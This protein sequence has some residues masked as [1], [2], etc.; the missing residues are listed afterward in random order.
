[1]S[2]RITLSLLM[3]DSYKNEEERGGKSI[4]ELGFKRLGDGEDADGSGF[5]AQ[6]YINHNTK[7]IVL[8]IAGTNGNG[9]VEDILADVNFATNL[10]YHQQFYD[11]LKYANEINELANGDDSA[12]AGYKITT[13]GHSLGGGHAQILSHTYGWDGVTWDAPKASLI[14]QSLGYKAQLAEYNLNPQGVSSNFVNYAES[15]SV[16]SV[17]PPF[18]AEFIGREVEVNYTSDVSKLAVLFGYTG[19][20]EIGALAGFF[21]HAGSQH[22]AKQS[23]HYFLEEQSLYEIDGWYHVGGT[24]NG[25]YSIEPNTQVGQN[26]WEGRASTEK[27]DEL[28]Q[29]RTQR[30]EHNKHIDQFKLIVPDSE[31]FLNGFNNNVAPQQNETPFELGTGFNSSQYGFDISTNFSYG[32]SEQ[33]AETFGAE[34]NSI[35]NNGLLWSSGNA[36]FSSVTA[37]DGGY[38]TEV[39]AAISDGYQPGRGNLIDTTAS[40]TV[41]SLWGSN[42]SDDAGSFNLTLGLSTAYLTNWSSDLAE[43]DPLILDLDGDGVEL[44]PFGNGY[45]FFD[46]DNDGL[47]E[48]TGWVGADDA[49]LVHDINGDGKINDITETLSEYYGAGKGTGAVWSS[50]FAALQSLDTNQDG[51]V[52][53]ADYAFNKLRIW[54]DSNQ[55]GETD[56]GELKSLNEAGIVEF[57][58]INRVDGSFLGGNEI[59]TNGSYRKSDG[60]VYTLAA[61]N[62]IADPSG[63]IDSAD[64]L[65]RRV[66]IEDGASTYLVATSDGE[67]IDADERQVSNIVGGAGNDVLK[68]NAQNNWLVGSLGEDQIFGG[69]GEDY[70]IADAEDIAKSQ[71]NIQGGSGFDIVQFIDDQGVVFNLPKSQVVMVIGNDHADVIISGSSEQSIINGGAGN[72][73]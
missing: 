52:D 64:G 7:E 42:F 32:N 25:W 23:S 30:F 46:M 2:D 29:I 57:S 69:G 41:N 44:T 3:R 1:M 24:Y 4:E 61:V 27:A 33:E 62:F 20:G 45:I 53:A 40:Q 51:V 43:I 6:A 66:E 73:L 35:L 36:S 11:S 39:N 63:L 28:D 13:T 68:G 65:G 15:G 47:Q 49:I 60:E 58:L 8:A 18:Y 31:S 70:I 14:V 22:A 26:D 21:Y 19:L 55:N 5:R 10:A 17:L 9:L 59:K 72:D 71:D 16:V 34:A 12:Y 56:E 67:T 48:R 38:W 54:Q 37:N 50:S